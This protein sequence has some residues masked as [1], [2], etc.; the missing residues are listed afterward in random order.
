MEIVDKH[1]PEQ[2]QLLLAPIGD[3]QYGSQGVDLDK[4][5]K[6]VAYGIKHKWSFLGMGDYLDTF[7]PSNHAALKSITLYESGRALLDEAIERRVDELAKILKAPKG[8]WL[9]LVHGDHIAHLE[10]GQ[11]CDALLARKLDT[12]FLGTSAIVRVFVGSCPRPLRILVG[13]GAGASVSATGKTLHLERLLRAFDVDVVLLGHSHLKYGVAVDQLKAV[14]TKAGPKLV[15]ETKILGI[16]GSFLNGYQAGSSSAH[17][18]AEGGY[19]EKKMMSPH[20]TGGLLIE[21]TPVEE[22]WGWRFDMFVT[23]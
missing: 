19:V 9:G 11:S 22:E 15:N 2:K 14:E 21:A 20:P 13:H 12:T 16:T 3:I 17:G 7:S 6:H 1:L 23:S 8:R 5:K 4:L 18:W 10:D